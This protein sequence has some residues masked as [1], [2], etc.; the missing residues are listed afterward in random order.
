MG[1]KKSGIGVWSWYASLSLY[2]GFSRCVRYLDWRIRTESTWKNCIKSN[3][4]AYKVSNILFLW[5]FFFFL[6]VL[7]I[8][9]T[10]VHLPCQ[11][12][13]G[14]GW[15]PGV[16]A[17]GLLFAGWAPSMHHC[18]VARP[19]ATE[20][21]AAVAATYG[22]HVGWWRSGGCGSY[23]M[24]KKKILG[25]NWLGSGGFLNWMVSVPT[26][27][28]VDPRESAQNMLLELTHDVRPLW[29]QLTSHKIKSMVGVSFLFFF[30]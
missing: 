20:K 23:S 28:R 14:S 17:D 3:F 13:S 29:T 12:C 27:P 19:W 7:I 9:I 8:P 16:A 24:K 4:R 21:P 10:T 2:I 11:R 26:G 5:F 30:L 6:R 22:R 1:V 18:G 25:S 15:T